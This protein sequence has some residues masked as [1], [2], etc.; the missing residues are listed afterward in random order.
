M[1]H[2]KPTMSWAVDEAHLNEL[3]A[4]Y[5]EREYNE[6]KADGDSPDC[7]KSLIKC[8]YVAASVSDGRGN[9]DCCI[10][11]ERS[12]AVRICGMRNDHDDYV[13][14]ESDFYHLEG[15][16]KEQGLAYAEKE[17]EILI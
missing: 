14:F 13:Y 17:G 1:K 12:D 16:C 8:E 15:W 4:K 11:Q 3:L 2:I 5:W 6:L 9:N 7:E 10:V